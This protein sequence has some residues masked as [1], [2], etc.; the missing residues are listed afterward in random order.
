MDGAQRWPMPSRARLLAGPGPAFHAL[1]EGRY[2]TAVET[3]SAKPG[4]PSLRTRA[5]NA[6][7]PW[8]TAWQS[9]GGGAAFDLDGH[10]A[11]PLDDERLAGS[12]RSHR[13]VILMESHRAPE[14]VRLGT[15]LL[16]SLRAA[17]A[18]HLAFETYLQDPLD[19]FQ[20]SGCLLPD[21]A[22]YAFDPSQAALLRTARALG[23]RLVAF[24]ITAFSL[25]SLARV[26]VRGGYREI[27]RRRE[28][29]MAQNIVQLLERDRAA[30]VVVWTGEQHAWKRNPTVW[31]HPFMAEHLTRLLGEEPFCVGQHVVRMEGPPTLRLLAGNHPWAAERG[32]DAVVLH[33]RSAAPMCPPWLEETLSA[34]DVEPAG[35]ALVQAIPEEGCAGTVPA[36]Q[37][38]THGRSQRLLVE[39]GCYL[40]RGITPGDQE[41]WRRPVTV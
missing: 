40:V 37:R 24:D 27:D 11:P 25:F 1:R 16:P 34:L 41:L 36:D 9:S 30:R 32:L 3:L 39:R 38:L 35:A 15:R 26:M 21:T 23:L 8:D 22:A 33:H 31:R 6:V 4:D 10:P 29:S 12:M 18:T 20:S 17:G 5:L 19:R 13:V 14:T 28:E 7:D 2:L